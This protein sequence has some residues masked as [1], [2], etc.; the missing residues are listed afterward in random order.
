MLGSAS[1][2][3]QRFWDGNLPVKP[4]AIAKAMGFKVSPQFGQTGGYSGCIERQPDGSVVI[5]YDL[6]E[7]RVRQRFTIAHE[8]GHYALGHLRD[9]R[10]RFRDMASNFSTG[11]YAPEET[12]ANR[13]A[14]DLLMPAHVL[15]YVVVDKGV[16]DV[17]HLANAFD[18]SQVAMRYRLQNL[19]LL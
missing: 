18:V 17:E 2:L 5:S 15:R 7:P 16:S 3:L 13:F 19:G 8:I 10:T 12:E 9:G 4:D 6:T 1:D 11:T 14:A